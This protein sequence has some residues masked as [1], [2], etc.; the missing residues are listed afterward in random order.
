MESKPV[1]IESILTKWESLM[2]EPTNR[3][4]IKKLLAIFRACRIKQVEPR[5]LADMLINV[6][7]L[8]GA[9]VLPYYIKYRYAENQRAP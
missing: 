2:S 9:L 8:S 7:P 4:D 5:S 1:Y 3:E 6:Q